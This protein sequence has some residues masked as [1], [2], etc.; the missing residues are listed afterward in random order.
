M[1]LSSIAKQSERFVIYGRMFVPLLGINEDP[2]K[3]NSCT[4]MI[5]YINKYKIVNWGF[6]KRDIQCYQ[7]DSVDRERTVLIKFEFANN[8]IKK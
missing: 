6:L 8:N 2:V 1:F 3:G 4:P 7:G 5:T